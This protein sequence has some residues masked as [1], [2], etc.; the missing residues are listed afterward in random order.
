MKKVVL[1]T[2]VHTATDT[3][4]FYKEARALAKRGYEVTLIAQNEKDEVIDGVYIK[5]LP[6]PN[7]RFMRIL[8]LTLLTFRVAIKQKADIYHFHDPELIPVGALLKILTGARV[9][10]DVHEDVPKQILTKQWIPPHLHQLIAVLFAI[11]EKS[12]ANV[13]DAIIVA[14]EEISKRFEKFDPIVVHNFPDFRMLP[15]KYQIHDSAAEKTLV[16]VGGISRIRGV[17][18]MIQAMEYVCCRHKINLLLIGRYEPKN[19]KM[20]LQNL[21]GYQKV[22]SLGHL[23][24][25]EAWATAK[26]AIAGLVLFHPVPN[27]QRS[28][29]NKLFEYMAAGIPVVASNFPLWREIIEGNHC[30]ICVDP[31]KP[32]EIAAAIEYLISNPEKARE[33]G[34]NGRRAVVEKYNWGSEEIKLLNLYRELLDEE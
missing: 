2:T 4:I 23:P 31:L 5:A 7:N 21:L 9:I 14:T 8:G 17:E 25:E 18:E 32:K 22:Q 10:Y 3:R 27:H 19:L 11:L 28:L 20:E 15:I 29:P 34:E 12:L 24:W 33:M 6:R 13:F 26:N 30:G 1:V 16:Y